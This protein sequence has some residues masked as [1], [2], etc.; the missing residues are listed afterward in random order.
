VAVD[1]DLEFA[2]KI[3]MAAERKVGLDSLLQA[4]Q[5]QLLKLPRFPL[6]EGLIHHVDEGWSSPERE[7]IAQ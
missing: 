7:R 6:S 2:D 5:P 1:Q 4:G 3:S